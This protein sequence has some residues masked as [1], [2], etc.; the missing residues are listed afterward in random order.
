M[1]FTPASQH[2][3]QY[4]STTTTMPNNKA[5]N[6]N[7][8]KDNLNYKSSIDE[9]IMMKFVIE[10][11]V[12][13]T[14]LLQRYQDA[15]EQVTANETKLMLWDV[16]HWAALYNHCQLIKVVLAQRKRHAL[17]GDQLFPSDKY[18]VTALHVAVQQGH[19]ESVV[20]LLSNDGTCDVNARDK[21]PFLRLSALHLAVNRPNPSMAI[22]Q[23][24]LEHGA[25]VNQETTERRTPLFTCIQRGHSLQLIELLL[26][27]GASI[28]IQDNP[29]TNGWEYYRVM[30]PFHLAI[31]RGDL[32]II[33]SL[34]KHGG[35]PKLFLKDEVGERLI[36]LSTL[37]HDQDITRLLMDNGADINV[38]DNY[39][40]TPLDYAISSVDPTKP[41]S[42]SQDTFVQHLINHYQA[43]TG[44]GRKM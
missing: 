11:S 16:L 17:T 22:I 43:K 9:S 8:N 27:H 14:A 34:I 23:T 24:L 30:T 5:N 38:L 44:Q 41:D 42:V 39:G 18:G 3:V 36:H 33:K 13:E 40:A 7:N 21:K 10:G 19:L 12:D 28:N 15:V 31:K 29:R 20:A 4:S 35:D 6:N 2:R 25:N 37:Q 1:L 32:D 26:K